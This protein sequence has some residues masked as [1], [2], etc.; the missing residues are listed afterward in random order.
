MRV[1]GG[2][3]V[4]W[5][6]ALRAMYGQSAGTAA[7]RGQVLDQTAAAITQAEVGER[8]LEEIKSEPLAARALP[9]ER[10]GIADPS[11]TAT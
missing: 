9:E 7:I 10:C 4:I 5:G 6:L 8:A 2:L 3:V 11:G 1:F